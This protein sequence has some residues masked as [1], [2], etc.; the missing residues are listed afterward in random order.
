MVD[1]G[2]CNAFFFFFCV[3]NL[4]FQVIWMGDFVNIPGKL[5]IIKQNNAIR[6]GIHFFF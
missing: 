3:E 5:K 1:S 6:C 4:H 2:T